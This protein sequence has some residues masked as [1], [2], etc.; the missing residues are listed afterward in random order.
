MNYKIIWHKEALD[1]LKRLDAQ[2]RQKIFGK[3]ETY[4]SKDPIG[5]GKPLKQN[6]AGMF[7]YRYVN[8]RIIYV[9]NMP[10]KSMV[11]LEIG[12]RK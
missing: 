6:L 11:I 12:H 3:V 1:D 5:L 7:R 8:Y 2:L 9:V 10:E 4:L